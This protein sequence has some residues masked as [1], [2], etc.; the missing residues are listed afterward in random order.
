MFSTI[1]EVPDLA[2]IA[3]LVP[4]LKDCSYGWERCGE[5]TGPL[6][7][8]EPGRE[9]AYYSYHATEAAALSSLAASVSEGSFDFYESSAYVVDQEARTALTVRSMGADGFV[10]RRG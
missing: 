9:E 5:G 2:P 6:V 3:D 7:L 8:I 4:A 1:D 10:T